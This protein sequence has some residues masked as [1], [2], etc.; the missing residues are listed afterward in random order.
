MKWFALP[1]LLRENRPLTCCC[2]SIFGVCLK[3]SWQWSSHTIVGTAYIYYYIFFSVCGVW[4]CQFLFYFKH[5]TAAD[6]ETNGTLVLSFL[7][8]FH[9]CSSVGGGTAMQKVGLWVCIR[10]PARL[11]L[12]HLWAQRSGGS[13]LRESDGPVNE[14]VPAGWRHPWSYRYSRKSIFMWL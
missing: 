5:K 4:V 9:I 13:N 11:L 1:I 12:C 14:H 3:M 7:P 8:S 2:I 10:A 6:L